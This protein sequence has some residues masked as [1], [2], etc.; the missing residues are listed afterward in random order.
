MMVELLVGEK[1]V[2]LVPIKVEKLVVKKVGWTE[3]LL[4][5]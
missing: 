1:V 5:V 3:I 2:S 4:V